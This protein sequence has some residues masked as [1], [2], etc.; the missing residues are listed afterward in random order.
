MRPSEQLTIDRQSDSRSFLVKNHDKDFY[1][2]IPKK[3]STQIRFLGQTNNPTVRFFLSRVESVS[4][5][6]KFK[7][8]FFICSSGA[9]TQ[10]IK[11]RRRRF[12]VSTMTNDGKPEEYGVKA[13]EV[14]DLKY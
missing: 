13:D 7:S 6:S 1:F 12:E 11:V 3:S 5:A 2:T 9:E 14:S 4:S 8:R 10:K